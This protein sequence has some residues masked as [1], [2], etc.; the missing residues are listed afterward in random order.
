MNKPQAAAVKT[1]KR[2]TQPTKATKLE[3]LPI[4]NRELSWL[5]FN[6]RVLQEAEDPNVP[7]LEK[8]KF[9]SI[10]SSNLDEFF[11]VRV[12]SLRRIIEYEKKNKIKGVGANEKLLNSIQ[13]TVLK[14]QTIFDQTYEHVKDELAAQKV[15]IINEKQLNQTQKVE[16]RAYFKQ[17][18][19]SAL[20]PV[21]LDHLREFPF[22]RD[23]SIYLAVKMTR[24]DGTLRQRYA[25]I[26]IPRPD[27]I[28]RFYVFNKTDD[29]TFVILLDDI[30]RSALDEIFSSF[31]YD[32]FEA[33]TI[34]VTRDAELD[35]DADTNIS[36]T[37]MEKISKSLKERRK[38]IPVRFIHDK[39]IPD[40]MLKFIVHRL[41]I[42]GP[43]IIAGGR[44]HNF[45][46]L[47]SFPSVGLERFKNPS[48]KQIPVPQLDNARNM[49]DAVSQN[50]I[51]LHHPYHSFD[52]LIR[53]LREA[54]IDPGVYAIKI[55]LYRVSRH[56]HIVNALINAVKNGKDVTAVIEL[57][58]RFDEES[59]LYWSQRLQE[60]GAKV[61]FGKPSHKIHSKVCLIYRKENNRTVHY[62]H[63]STGNYNGVTA[64]LYCD[65]GLLT[66]D[67]R[68]TQEAIKVFSLINNFPRIEYTF[69]HLLVAP[70]YM[71]D[72]FL[73]LI[74]TEIKNAKRGKP[75]YIIAKMNS[76]V[77]EVVID[78]LYTASK[79][80][81]KIQLIIRGICCLKPGLPGISENITA[82]SIVDKFLEHTRAY[83]FCN[84]GNEKYYLSSA[85]WM[86]RNLDRRIEVAFPIFDPKIQ[87]T[88]KDILEIQLNDNVKAR[89]IDGENDTT[90]RP[91]GLP[92]VRSQEEVYNYL[93]G[94]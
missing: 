65:L 47:G 73:K 46:D 25:L 2:K 37:L 1:A 20:F 14:Q 85:D 17:H 74:D 6:E 49:F 60:E 55:T 86:G 43:G 16:L 18:V 44:Y 30:I 92:V 7:L 82:I 52:Y 24:A 91:F 19:I 50:D 26:E 61:I 5:S 3:T 84:G 22:L 28:S 53:M 70:F 59:N 57:Q 35:L 76:L 45:R 78:R 56:S 11:R 72:E 54:A 64:R 9:L 69:K 21:I 36:D 94:K 90:F 13:Q 4:K 62:A 40:D 75:A 12:A 42:S 83:I 10:F 81:V 79:A 63:F 38:G 68:L 71:K 89:I 32:T 51:L 93:L 8:L 88:V 33:Y 41:H 48:I 29:N 66:A 39:D 58:A 27:E 15:F 67:K 31:T 80:G 34:K 87:K 77:D 23:R